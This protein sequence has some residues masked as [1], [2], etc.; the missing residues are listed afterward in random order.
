MT[1]S[2]RKFLPMLLR[3]GKGYKIIMLE[4]KASWPRQR[5]YPCKRTARVVLT[6]SA[7]DPLVYIAAPFIKAT[8]EHDRAYQPAA[9]EGIS[10]RVAKNDG[11]EFVTARPDCSPAYPVERR[12]QRDT[13]L[14]AGSKDMGC[15]IVAAHGLQPVGA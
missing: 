13:P 3:F 11:T 5:I 15:G 14:M 6:R 9:G 4:M 10:R 1:I 12:W 7:N 2:Q 8:W